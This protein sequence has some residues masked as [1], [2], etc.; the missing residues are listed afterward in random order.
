MFAFGAGAW[1]LDDWEVSFCDSAH[2]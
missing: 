2:T 1:Y